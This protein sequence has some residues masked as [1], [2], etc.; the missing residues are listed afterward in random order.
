MQTGNGLISE[1]NWVHAGAK[2]SATAFRK[3]SH[4]VG[5]A[6]PLINSVWMCSQSI[7]SSLSSHLNFPTQPTYRTPNAFLEKLKRKSLIM[8]T[9]SMEMTANIKHDASAF[10]GGLHSPPSLLM[11]WTES[12]S[13][14]TEEGLEDGDWEKI[15]RLRKHWN[16][17]CLTYMIW[18]LA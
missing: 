3:R 7:F 5:W 4:L 6:A 17:T 2:T 10:V 15:V 1:R 8:A 16:K 14:T 11:I 9:V 12:D 13:H 18:T